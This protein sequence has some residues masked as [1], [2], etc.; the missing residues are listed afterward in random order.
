MIEADVNAAKAQF[1]RRTE[2][3][4]HIMALEN[5]NMFIETYTVTIV[6]YGAQ[7]RQRSWN[8]FK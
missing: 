3:K 1:E 4:V 2:L 7:E 6:S 5:R 8:R